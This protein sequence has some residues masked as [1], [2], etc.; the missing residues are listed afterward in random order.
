[1]SK[2]IDNWIHGRM[3]IETDG[4]EI[5]IR[6]EPVPGEPPPTGKVIRIRPTPA[7]VRHWNLDG[8]P[9]SPRRIAAEL[10]LRRAL[11]VGKVVG[12]TTLTVAGAAMM[13][14]VPWT[15]ALPAAGVIAAGSALGIGGSKSLKEAN[16]LEPGSDQVSNWK[17]LLGI[18]LEIVKLIREWI[19][20]KKDESKSTS[21]SG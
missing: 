9:P 17:I 5:I 2:D 3:V 18:I 8:D 10:G 4:P 19:G 12:A 16:N 6:P 15:V 11:H 7:Q 21:D 20:R 14:G 1:M 13:K